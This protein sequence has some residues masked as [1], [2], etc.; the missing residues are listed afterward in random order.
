MKDSMWQCII[1]TTNIRRDI[2]IKNLTG[3][4][5]LK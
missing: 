3:T 5:E 1:I 4:K 2:K